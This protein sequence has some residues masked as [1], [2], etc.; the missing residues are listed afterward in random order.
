MIIVFTRDQVARLQCLALEYV[1]QV[2]HLLNMHGGATMEATKLQL[3]R[4]GLPAW[5]WEGLSEDDQRERLAGLAAQ[6]RI[7]AERD[8]RKVE[9]ER[10]RQLAVQA[11]P[12]TEDE[13]NAWWQST[14]KPQAQAR[15]MQSAMAAAD[16][17][18]RVGF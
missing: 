9:L 10:L 13:F 16:Q 5:Q 6:D 4:L 8:P 18:N 17:A 1:Q 14:G 3:D 15:M 7:N 2:D 11:F 12:G